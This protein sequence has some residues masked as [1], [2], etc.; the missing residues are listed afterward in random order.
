MQPK[1]SPTADLEGKRGLFFLIG[2]SLA[3]FASVLVL[4]IETATAGPSITPDPEQRGIDEDPIPITHLSRPQPKI[5]QATPSHDKLSLV[6]EIFQ[7]PVL[8]TPRIDDEPL[9]QIEDEPLPAREVEAIPFIVVEKLAVPVECGGFSQR[10]E[11]LDCL[12]QWVARYI[13]QRLDLQKMHN[14]LRTDSRVVVSFEVSREGEIGKVKI[15]QSGF[16][17]LDRQVVQ[18]VEEMPAFLPASQVGKK[19]PMSMTIPLSVKFR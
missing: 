15:L 16:Y 18:I 2:L 14:P 9:R 11:Q 1:K 7:K 3:L 8:P 5:P 10:E 19:V 4:Q 17:D 12:N 13:H 6:D